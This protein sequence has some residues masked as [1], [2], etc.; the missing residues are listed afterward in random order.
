LETFMLIKSLFALVLALLSSLAMA[1][2]ELNS[3]DQA[4]LESVRGIGPSLSAKLLA[5][6]KK[7]AFKDWA[8]VVDRVPGVGM[9]SAA[10]LSAAGLTVQ[11]QPM[12]APPAAAVRRSSSSAN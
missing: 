8:D 11:G 7:A 12:G 6:R 1:A 9:A 5:E 2:V 10:K 4:A 3:A